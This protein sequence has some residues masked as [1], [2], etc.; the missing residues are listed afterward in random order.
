MA[1]QAQA[2]LERE[3]KEL[4][5][6][7]QRISDQAQQKVRGRSV[8]GMRKGY[9]QVGGGPG[10]LPRWKDLVFHPWA[11]LWIRAL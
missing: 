2:D 5:D 8:W 4:E 3:K 9:A 11:A 10:A 6:S 1:R 7:F